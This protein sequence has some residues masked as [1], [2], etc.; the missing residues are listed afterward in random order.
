[1]VFKVGDL[2]ECIEGGGGGRDGR[3]EAGKCYV[4]MEYHDEVPPMVRVSPAPNG[5]HLFFAERFRLFDEVH[6]D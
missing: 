2:V 6:K 1:M 5:N 4:V 3:V